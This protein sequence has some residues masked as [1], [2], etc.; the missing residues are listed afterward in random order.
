[1]TNLR[2]IVKSTLNITDEAVINEY[3]VYGM[4]SVKS[5]QLII[6]KNDSE[7]LKQSLTEEIFRKAISKK[8]AL[9]NGLNS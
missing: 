8:Y 6:D 7:G 9:S 5:N 4:D 1:M 2:D 3:Y